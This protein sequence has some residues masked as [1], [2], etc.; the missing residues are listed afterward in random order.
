MQTL[1]PKQAMGGLPSNGLS[2]LRGE[3]ALGEHALG[4]VRCEQHE[5]RAADQGGV[6]CVP[7][8]RARPHKGIRSV[9]L[10]GRLACKHLL[11]LRR[12][13]DYWGTRVAWVGEICAV[14]GV[15]GLT[16]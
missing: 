13:S 12:L 2:I 9:G 3:H 5:G 4:V 7:R 11:L 14:T 6:P 10:A 1:A 16:D 8:M 15:G